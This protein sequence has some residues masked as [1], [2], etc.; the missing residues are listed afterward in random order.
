MC[1]YMLVYLGVHLCLCVYVG[2]DSNPLLM[3]VWLKAADKRFLEGFSTIIL[4]A[5]IRTGK[6]LH[7]RFFSY[8]HLFNSNI[9]SLVRKHEK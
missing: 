9:C 7:V 6:I 8:L 1:V 5:I 4:M 2:F 3:H